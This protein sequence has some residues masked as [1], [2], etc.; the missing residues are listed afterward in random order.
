MKT[1][2]SKFFYFLGDF[3][4]FKFSSLTYPLYRRLM[5]IS[6]HFDSNNIVWGD[7]ADKQNKK[8]DFIVKLK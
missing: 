1:Y 4:P 8:R 5:L 6:I 2:L 7:E 3:V